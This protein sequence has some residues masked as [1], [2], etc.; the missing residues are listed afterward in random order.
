MNKGYDTYYGPHITV[1]NF[2]SAMAYRMIGRRTHSIVD[3]TAV[4][5]TVSSLVDDR[6]RRE[7]IVS[8][9]EICLW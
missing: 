9:R 7:E 3:R 1:S 6:V 8:K 2:R 4:C 5:L